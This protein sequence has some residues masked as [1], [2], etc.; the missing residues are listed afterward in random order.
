MSKEKEQRSF[1]EQAGEFVNPICILEAGA[2]GGAA[3]GAMYLLA[4]NA[5]DF[6]LGYAALCGLGGLIG[7]GKKIAEGGDIVLNA[8]EGGIQGAGVA[9]ALPATIPSVVLGGLGALYDNAPKLVDGVKAISEFVAT[10]IEQ[11]IAREKEKTD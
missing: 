10:S 3:V 7:A 5:P 1:L 2:I 9:A 4:N 6:A 8:V 11:A